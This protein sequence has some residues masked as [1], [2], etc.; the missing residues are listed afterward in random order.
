[1][2]A[3]ALKVMPPFWVQVTL[4]LMQS[5]PQENVLDFVLAHGIVCDWSIDEPPPGSNT[6]RVLCLDIPEDAQRENSL[7]FQLPVEEFEKNR[8]G[9][10]LTI[11]AT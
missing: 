5:H 2:E 11:T 7:F 6:V 8:G 10:H 3:L 1:M 4:I 9:T